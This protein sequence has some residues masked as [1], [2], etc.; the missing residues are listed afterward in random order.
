MSYK[1]KSNTG[2][3][4]MMDVYFE[5]VRIYGYNLTH[6]E[7]DVKADAD[8]PYWPEKQA[9]FEAKCKSRIPSI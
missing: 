7:L 2:G 9:N 5:S 8:R 1:Q 6:K 4:F 3:F